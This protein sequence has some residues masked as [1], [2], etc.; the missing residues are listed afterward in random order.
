MTQH[1][2]TREA[3]SL[4]QANRLFTYRYKRLSIYLVELTLMTTPTPTGL[5]Y[6]EA[7]ATENRL[8]Q[9]LASERHQK[10]ELLNGRVAMLGFVIGLLTEAI[11]GQGIFGQITFGIFGCS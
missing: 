4:R 10:A 6:Q 5:W 7:A 2:L 11:T 9:L 1:Q 3:K 8:E